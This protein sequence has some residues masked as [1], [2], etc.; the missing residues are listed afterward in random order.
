MMNVRMSS[1]TQGA[2]S[3]GKPGNLREF[4]NSGK[5]RELRVNIGNFLGAAFVSQQ[6]LTHKCMCVC[7]YYY[8]GT[9]V[10]C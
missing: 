8:S 4:I 7:D 5:L 2:Y 3:C 1:F 10:N 6:A 9:Y